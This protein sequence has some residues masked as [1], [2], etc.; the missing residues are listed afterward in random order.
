MH[1]FSKLFWKPFRKHSSLF[2]N[3]LYCQNIHKTNTSFGN[4][5][6]SK[7]PSEKPPITGFR[8]D[9]ADRNRS[10]DWIRVLRPISGFGSID[11]N[12]SVDRS[13][14]CH[15]LP[16]WIGRPDHGLS[17]NPGAQTAC[18]N[19]PVYQNLGENGI[20]NQIG[21]PNQTTLE[22]WN[23]GNLR[24]TQNGNHNRSHHRLWKISQNIRMQRTRSHL[25]FKTKITRIHS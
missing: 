4:T 13:A 18:Q 23:Q 9:S 11:R 22:N 7:N 12:R 19:G 2:A 25:P 17:S 16:K 14:C 24:I 15:G 1:F 21:M 20:P 8:S 3:H 5:K 10:V 6:Q